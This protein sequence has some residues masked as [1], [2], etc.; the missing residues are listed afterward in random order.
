MI[1]A[2][3]KKVQYGLRIGTAYLVTLTIVS[4]KLFKGETMVR[5][6]KFGSFP[7]L[8]NEMKKRDLVRTH[9]NQGE[10]LTNY[11][12]RTTSVNSTIARCMIT[13]R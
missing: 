8:S 5:D 11:D 7:T 2:P 9:L 6:G 12:W 4:C 10:K 13:R 1:P 3:A